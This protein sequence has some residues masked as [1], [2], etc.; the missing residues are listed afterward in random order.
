MP[1][2][3]LPNATSTVFLEQSHSLPLSKGW[4]E[5]NTQNGFSPG[6]S[7]PY[8]KKEKKV[9]AQTQ[10]SSKSL[11]KSCETVITAAGDSRHPSN[12]SHASAVVLTGSKG[13]YQEA[14]QGTI[15]PRKGWKWLS[16][17]SDSKIMRTPSSQWHSLPNG[18]TDLPGDNPRAFPPMALCRMGCPSHA[19]GRT[20]ILIPSLS[21]QH[22]WP[23][24]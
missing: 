1:G 14:G 11:R 2:V 19:S 23:L 6:L 16:T 15:T 5:Y 4:T 12:T 9:K 8:C 17:V 10:R 13:R 18:V 20:G 3:N 21:C 7:G 22:I 24:P